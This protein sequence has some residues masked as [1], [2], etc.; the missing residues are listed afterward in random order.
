MGHDLSG[1]G[2]MGG[3]VL[4][5]GV[6]GGGRV[7]G[8]LSSWCTRNYALPEPAHSGAFAATTNGLASGN[9][10][11]EALL[12]ALM[13]VIERDAITLWKLG[14]GPGE[15]PP[16]C[17]WR[18]SSD[19]ACRWLLD[20]FAAAGIEVAAWDVRS[21]R[22]RPRFLALIQDR[23]RRDGRGRARRRR[24]SGARGG[25]GPGADRGGAGARHIHRRRPRG[26][27]G[28][29]LCAEALAER[30]AAVEAILATLAPERD[31]R[32]IQSTETESFEGDVA[33]AL[34]ALRRVGIDEAIAVDLAR[35]ALPF[36]VVR[37]V[38]PG[39]EAALEGPASAYVPGARAAALL[40]SEA[41]E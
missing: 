22:R 28:R 23:H 18:R 14:P 9:T 7:A 38:V 30:R 11:A 3:G 32:G 17:G 27:P 26:H 12:H 39:L 20:R 10:K 4:G 15:M 40:T 21:D 5:G 16:P 1:G 34:S 24:P 8:C 29:R 36:A 13:E 25:A 41:A 19:P 2:M 33:A 37:V 6:L 31:F 35:P